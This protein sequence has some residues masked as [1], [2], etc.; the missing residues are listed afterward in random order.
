MCGHDTGLNSVLGHIPTLPTKY[1]SH[2]GPFLNK[3]HVLV[4]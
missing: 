3:I 2:G 1:S 4:Q